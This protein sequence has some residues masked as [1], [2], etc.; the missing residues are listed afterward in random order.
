MNSKLRFLG[1]MLAATIFLSCGGGSAAVKAEV[2]VKVYVPKAYQNQFGDKFAK[3]DD[4]LRK[5][6]DIN[7]LL[8]KAAADVDDFTSN[9]KMIIGDTKAAISDPESALAAFV[10]SLKSAKV[11]VT[12]RLEIY[13][14]DG[15]A[16]FKVV[17]TAS[18]E[19]PA[20]IQAKIDAFE[21]V[22][23]S[24]PSAAEEVTA[25][26]KTSVQLAQD[27]KA[28]AQSAPK[29]FTGLDA[30]NAPKAAGALT[31]AAAK[32]AEVPSKV[33]V[34]AKKLSDLLYYVNSA[35]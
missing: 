35:F 11:S 20:D 29:D 27:C 26:G 23:K 17:P 15:K 4:T 13:A 7:E 6:N 33:T 5:A 30:L 18:V 25:A 28:L 10:D 9:L 34:L 31:D 14:E 12:L 24:L 1:C 21:K 8:V 2:Q 32:L 3:Y 22:I 16:K 19:I